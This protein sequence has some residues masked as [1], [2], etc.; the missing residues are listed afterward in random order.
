MTDDGLTFRRPRP[1]KKRRGWKRLAPLGALALV[2]GG[3]LLGKALWPSDDV[4]PGVLVEVRGEVPQPGW[5]R[6]DPPTVRAALAAAGAEGGSAE[7]L[8][9]GDLVRRTA[10]GVT[11]SPS[12]NPL[13]VALPVDVNQAGLE[14]LVAVPGIGHETARAIVA[15]RE[16]H[17]PFYAIADLGRV[18]GLGPAT[19]EEIAPLLTVGDVGPRPERR[20]LDL[21]LASAAE[22]ERLPHIGPVTAARIIVDREENGPFGSLDDLAR[23]KGIGP[24]TVEAVRG[25]ARVGDGPDD[26]DAGG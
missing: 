26:T 19:V 3:L 11:V 16:A 21:N 4:P 12:G 1:E 18:R 10:D 25:L 7:P 14:A 6:V 24:K 13:L 8:H 15:S 20:P 9:E 22:L 17:G 2:S 5:H 23:V